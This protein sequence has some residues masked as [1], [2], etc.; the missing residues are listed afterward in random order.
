MIVFGAPSRYIQ[1]PGCLSSIGDELLRFGGRAALVIDAGVQEALLP[2]IQASCD[3]AGLSPKIIPFSGESSPEGIDNLERQLGDLRPD[4]VVAAGGGKCID[5][6]KALGNRFGSRVATIPTIASNDSPTSH[7]YVL[8][9]SN[10]RL[11][12]VEALPTNP[13]LVLVDTDVILNAPAVFLLAGIGDCVVKKFEV[14]ACVRAS[15]R[16]VFGSKPSMAALSMARGA[17]EILRSDSAAALD[18]VA[19]RRPGDEFE[20]V[21][22]ACVLLSGL[23]FENGGLSI[24]HA[25]TRGLSMVKPAADALHGLQVAYGVTIQ[26]IL[27]DRDE[28][29][30]ADHAAFYRQVGLPL[31]LAGLGQKVPSTEILELIA[32]KTL[33]APHMANFPA[34]VSGEQLTSAMRRAE[35]LFG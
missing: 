24:A 11:L 28:Q 34:S 23:S 13:D 21:V 10:H 33:A 25:M 6:G 30:L 17:Y 20:R 14:E 15:G 2:V 5:S 26:L 16:N 7:I 22:E 27:E 1:G 3:A 29:F 35:K 19:R 8:Y 31:T 4:V 32:E 9:D 12:R 18:S